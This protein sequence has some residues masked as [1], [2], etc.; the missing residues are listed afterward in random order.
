[1]IIE[2][3][4]RL[5]RVFVESDIEPEAVIR[6]ISDISGSRAKGFF[7]RV[8]LVEVGGSDEGIKVAAH[9]YATWGSF[10][11]QD[12]KEIF[13]PEIKQKGTGI[14]FF[15]PS[16]G[17]PLVPQGRYPVPVYIVYDKQFEKFRKEPAEIKKF[18]TGRLER[19]KGVNVPEATL[20]LIAQELCK[21]FKEYSA[22]G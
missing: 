11:K 6:Q 22:N 19:T 12:A 5:G 1:M 13:Q 3:V 21:R 20:N 10:I 2:N 16:G 8:F 15:V 17:N 18:L 9:P 7:Q 14:P 4:I